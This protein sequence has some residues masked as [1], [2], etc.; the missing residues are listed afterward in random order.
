[1]KT[2]QWIVTLILAAG[3]W[4]AAGQTTVDL[5]RQGKLGTGTTLPARCT[6]GQVFF[7]TD[8]PSGTNLYACAAPNTWAAVGL[9]VLGGDADRNVLHWNAASGQWEPG[10]VPAGGSAAPPATCT[11]GGF[12]LQS[13]LANHIQQLYVCS[14]A[15]TWSMASAGAGPSS[16]RPAGCQVGQTWLGTDSGVLSY[17]S[18]SGN[19]GT[20]NA[21]LAGAAGPAG[22]QGPAGNMVRNGI[23][24][25]ASATGT[26]G[27]FYLDTAVNCLYGPKTAGTWPGSCTSLGSMSNFSATAGNAKMAANYSAIG[28]KQTTVEPSCN[29]PFTGNMQATLCTDSYLGGLFN[30]ADYGNLAG[31]FTRQWFFN[32]RNSPDNNDKKTI[33]GALFDSRFA[34]AGQKS[35]I[36]NITYC[37]GVGD[38]YPMANV[39]YSGGY[40]SAWGDEGT[41]GIAN[42][43]FEVG[44]LLRVTTTSLTKTSCNTTLTAPV[45]KSNGGP[46]DIK[47]VSVATTVGCNMGDWVTIDQG[48]YESMGTSLTPTDMNVEVVQLTGVGS[49]TISALFQANHAAG[50]PV[51]PAPVLVATQN[52]LSREW[53]QGR[54]VVDLSGPAYSTGTA[55]VLG[56]GVTGHGTN[57][58]ASIV[59]GDANLAG[60]IAFDADNFHRDVFA[61]AGGPLVSWFPIQAVGGGGALTLSR[62]Y[63][64]KAT[65]NANYTIRPCARIGALAMSYGAASEAVSGI[66]LE[67]NAFPWTA[68]TT[69]EQ[70][71]S[72]YA[73]YQHG[74]HSLVSWYGPGTVGS[75]YSAANN[76]FTPAASAFDMYPS[77]DIDD[78]THAGY[79]Q[80]ITLRGNVRDCF[81]CLGG[82]SMN[83]TAVQIAT[84]TAGAGNPGSLL[85]LPTAGPGSG[86]IQPD[87]SSGA[88]TL[89]GIAGKVKFGWDRSSSY[90]FTWDYTAVTNAGHNNTITIPD[91]SGPLII[92]AGGTTTT[93][94]TP[95]NTTDAVAI[96]SF[97]GPETPGSYLLTVYASQVSKT[98][99]FSLSNFVSYGQWFKLAPLS[100]QSTDG[101][102]YDF[103]V[104]V[105]TDG[106]GVMNFRLRNTAL[107][108]G[109]TTAFISVF[110][111][112]RAMTFTPSTAVTTG[113]TPPPSYWPSTVL[114]GKGGTL[115]VN[116]VA[117]VTANGTSCTITSI[118]AGLI[119]GATCN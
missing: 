73:V 36:N 118:T 82:Q 51:N 18:A 77:G 40:N 11:A 57:W 69:V 74:V 14:S 25:P 96:G 29:L 10:F 83:G 100:A 112:G 94:A 90:G 48:V 15:N 21:T 65:T 19:P 110:A 93:R 103:D 13:D 71:I 59:G 76:G 54:V 30:P 79:N 47:T 42:Y 88:M 58:S 50:A 52:D 17:C 28:L 45:S 95:A 111:F 61:G 39:V 116:G 55:D 62:T 27:D 43:A 31:M 53:G 46:T 41:S 78:A 32:G 105:M 107:S 99:L 26:N 33:S 23:G 101:V 72:P 91:Q 4:Q 92:P 8:A 80:G 34:A 81:L 12:Y 37:Y 70:S 64:G 2:H 106:A 44:Q 56:T 20:W 102:T 67:S 35:G 84:S 38:C 75:L 113:V 22:P 6:V 87:L 49:G 117:G 86:Y 89:G 104:D 114:T 16:S 3:A 63:T 68:G 97:S 24:A 119:T 9:P 5:S 115:Y 66:V 98:Y 1:M 7:K 109:S 108:G 60:C 85:W